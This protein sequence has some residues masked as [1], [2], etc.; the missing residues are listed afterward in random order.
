MAGI[1]AAFEPP[2]ERWVPVSSRLR[3]VRRITLLL[4]LVPTTAIVLALLSMFDTT[5]AV[6]A[7]AALASPALAGH[8]K[9]GSTIIAR[10]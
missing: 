1:E 2:G 3:T 8:G 9:S 6:I 7:A 4:W 5:V 10:Q